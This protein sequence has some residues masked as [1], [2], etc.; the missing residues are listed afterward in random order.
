MC[1]SGFDECVPF[2]GDCKKRY[3]ANLPDG[4]N[5]VFRSHFKRDHPDYTSSIRFENLMKRV[6]VSYGIDSRG[7]VH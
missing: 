1:I 3:V 7:F 4:W 2:R 6:R 5:N